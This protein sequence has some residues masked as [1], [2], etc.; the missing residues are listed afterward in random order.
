MIYLDCTWIYKVP[1]VH[2]GVQ[3]VTRSII[4]EAINLRNDVYPAIL[5]DKDGLFYKLTDIPMPTDEPCSYKGSLISFVSGDIYFVLDSTWSIQILERLISYKKYGIITGAFYHDLIPIQHT[6]FCN[7]KMIKIFTSWVLETAKYADFFVCNSEVTKEN[8]KTETAKL[9][10]QRSLDDEIAFSLRLGADVSAYDVEYTPSRTDLLDA[11]D[12][13]VTYLIVATLEIRKN[14]KLLLDAFDSLWQRY[15]AIKLCFIGR[16]GWM[17]EELIKR[18]RAHP[19]LNKR[20]FWFEGLTDKDVQW[21]YR[22]AKCVLYPSWTEGFGLPIVEALYCEVPVLASDIPV[23]HEVGGEHIGYFDPHDFLSLVKWI[24]RIEQHGIPK[25]IVPDG[26]FKW[27]TWK[28]STEEMLEKTLSV[29]RAARKNL[30]PMLKNHAFDRRTIVELIRMGKIKVDQS[31]YFTE[32]SLINEIQ[33]EHS[34][35]N[36]NF[37]KLSLK[38]LLSSDGLE[39]IRQAYKSFLHRLPDSEEEKM[40]Y[41]RLKQGLP[42]IGLIFKIR[43]SREGRKIDEPV[44]HKFLLYLVGCLLATRKL[45]G[46]IARYIVSLFL[47]SVTRSM[48]RV[49]IMK[50]DETK[51]QL[52]E[53]KVQLNETKA[54]LHETKIKLDEVKIQLHETEAYLYETRAQLYETKTQLNETKMQSCEA[55]IKSNKNKKQLYDTRIYLNETRAQLDDMKTQLDDTRKQLSET[56]IELQETVMGEL[57]LLQKA[58][59]PLK[60]PFSYSS[61]IPFFLHELEQKIGQKLPSS[62]EDKEK[63]FYSYFAE[64]WSGDAENTI[65]QQHYESYLPHLPRNSSYPFLDIGCGAGEFLKFMQGHDIKTV[66]IDLN[67]TEIARCHGHGLRAHQAEAIDFLKSYDGQFSGISLL[68]VIEHI[69]QERYI[70]LLTLAKEKILENGILI[71]ETINLVHPL[72]FNVFFSDP[73]HIR[74]VPANYLTFMIQWCGFDSADILYLYPIPILQSTISDLQMHYHN[75]AIV[76]RKGRNTNEAID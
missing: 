45:H 18:V 50:L 53:T 37:E 44:R 35:N 60:L 43:F 26:N 6:E 66:G 19:M 54:Q 14:H 34:K 38:Q 41:E 55:E 22:K 64:I 8:L 9:Y 31:D 73:T 25:E 72:A 30:A 48:S 70:E 57:S 28:E 75:Y 10:P 12:R 20:L 32:H 16:E 2:T 42:P 68:Q 65:L 36:F 56:K 74:P 15:P 11:F 17:V 39:L 49:A 69:P 29:A 13:D 71:I 76:A 27:A 58:M 4:R 63:L 62:N 7:I 24:E 51:T 1:S 52:H 33:T 23:F 59:Q 21:A 61:K 40:Y 46:K 47:V 5:D 3:R 67:E